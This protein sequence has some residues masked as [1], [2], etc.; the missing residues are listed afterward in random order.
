MAWPTTK[1]G[2][3]NVDAGTDLVKNARADIKQNIDNVNS[4]IDEFDIASPSDGDL[5][6]YNS[7]SGAWETVTADS[8]SSVDFGV[9]SIT[10]GEE[11]V[12]GN[13][14]R[15]ALAETFDPNGIFSISATYQFVLGAGNYIIEVVSNSTATD[16]EAAVKVYDETNTTDLGTVASYNEISNVGEGPFLGFRSFTLTGSTNLSLRQTTAGTQDRNATLALKITK[17]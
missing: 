16:T 12:S 1:A 17:F 6:Q 11:N 15:R 2:T 13:I 10:V 9:I 14:Y 4:I 7:T 8:I 3:T 5:L